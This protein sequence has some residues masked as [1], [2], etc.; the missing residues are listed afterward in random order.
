MCAA[1]WGHGACVG[2]VMRVRVSKSDGGIFCTSTDLLAMRAMGLRCRA[3]PDAQTHTTQPAHPTHAQERREE[4]GFV[5]V[6]KGLG[7]EAALLFRRACSRFFLPPN[8]FLPL[9]R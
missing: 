2:C 4:R 5:L 3:T 7:P 9:C 6:V 8:A 1:V